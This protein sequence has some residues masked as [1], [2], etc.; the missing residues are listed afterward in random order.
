ML[1]IV[2]FISFALMNL[3]SG[4]PAEIMLSSQGSVVTPQLLESVREDMGLNQPFVTQYLNWL[5]NIIHGDFGTSYASG[6]SVIVEMNE[7]LPYT[8]KLAGSAMIITLI[9]SIPLGI[10]S[11]VKKDKFIDKFIRLFT[12]VGNSIPGFLLAL[13]LLLVFSL[14]LKLLPI[15]S[16][17][18]AKSIILP[19]V[20][21]AFAMTSKYIRQIRTAVI[22]EL[23][24]GYVKGARSRGIK[25][26]V[27]LYKDVLKNIMITVITLTGL[28][29]G[30]LMGGTAVVESIFVWPG[31]GSLALSSIANRDY[32]IIQAYVLWMA[33]MFI[34]INLIT[35][36][37]Y[38]II[39]PRVREV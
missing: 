7:H 15:L 14:K 3:S 23:D 36:L 30:S 39:D 2:S 35:D 16:E 20:T 5:K 8:I 32:P 33:V 4:D 12:F 1:I 17:S 9:V 24:K 37:L 26:S 34:I 10:L 29:I 13:I 22:E 18:G 19:S 21:L 28:S 27:I 11:A 38:K 31:V 6:R 25:E